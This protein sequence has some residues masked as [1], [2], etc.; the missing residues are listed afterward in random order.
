MQLNKEQRQD[1]ID[2]VIDLLLPVAV[3]D[4]AAFRVT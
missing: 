2:A 4:F 1:F 3:P